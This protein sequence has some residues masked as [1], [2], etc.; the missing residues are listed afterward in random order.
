MAKDGD[1]IES[2]LIVRNGDGSLPKPPRVG[3]KVRKLEGT[4]WRVAEPLDLPEEEWCEALKDA[5][6]TSSDAFVDASLRRLMAAAMVPG[7]PI[8]T[9]VSVSAALAVIQSLEPENEAQAALA[10]NAACLY[11][12][13]SNVMSRLDSVSGERRV[14][15]LAAAASR[16]SRAFHHAL[17]TYHR[18]KRGNTQVIRVEKLEILP[19]AQ[20]IVGN[21]HKG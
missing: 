14:V 7:E 12:A 15:A 21:V 3:A 16:L 20:A 11:A 5:L 17:E 18:L 13:S 4:T 9:S 1:E 6:G 10:L 19:G 8:A 2:K